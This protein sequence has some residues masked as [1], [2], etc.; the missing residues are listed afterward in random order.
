MRA[1]W[2]VPVK[3][4]RKMAP[5][6]RLSA[7]RIF[8]PTAYARS[9]TLVSLPRRLTGVFESGWIW[10]SPAPEF[11]GSGRDHTRWL[12]QLTVEEL[13]RGRGWGRAILIATED[14]CVSIGVEWIWL[15]VFNWNQVARRLYTSHG[16][17]LANQFA[18]DAHLR[19]ILLGT[20]RPTP[21]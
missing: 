10:L 17:E 8:W 6:R 12:S 20:C 7:C 15:R 18:T 2:L 16:Y 13:H 9:V 1:N 19:M 21:A 5:P 3:S 11:I 14:H 4:L